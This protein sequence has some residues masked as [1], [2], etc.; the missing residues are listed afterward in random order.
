M[1]THGRRLLLRP[2]KHVGRTGAPHRSYIVVGHGVSFPHGRPT[3]GTSL[4]ALSVFR[5]LGFGTGLDPRQAIL[6]GPHLGPLLVGLSLGVVSSSTTGTA[7]GYAGANM[8]PARC[9]ALSVARGDYSCTL[10]LG[11]GREKD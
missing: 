8:N 4:I 2:R 7:E 10:P 9:L 3:R 5:F 6:F 11:L 1:E